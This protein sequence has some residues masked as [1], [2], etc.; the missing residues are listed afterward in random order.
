MEEKQK[1]D[2]PS[3]D[4]LSVPKAVKDAVNEIGVLAQEFQYLEDKA[5]LFSP[6]GFWSLSLTWIDPIWRWLHGES[7]GAICQEYGLFE[8]N[9]VR[10]VLRVA[11]MVD[12][13]TAVATLAEDL[14][15]L[16]KLHDVKPRL[17]RDILVPDSLYLHL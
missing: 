6:T 10:A 8:G 7:A 15:T 5:R 4:D 16:E 11:N 3:L 1:D 17:I 12:E 13:W 14:E 9:F 2:G